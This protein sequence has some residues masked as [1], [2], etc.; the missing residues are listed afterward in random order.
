MKQDDKW[1]YE[2]CDFRQRDFV[3]DEVK[4]IHVQSY[5][6]LFDEN[7]IIKKVTIKGKNYFYSIH[8]DH[9]EDALRIRIKVIAQIASNS[10]ERI[11]K[12]IRESIEC[13]H[14]FNLTA[15]LKS[16]N[17]SRKKKEYIESALIMSKLTEK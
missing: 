9:Y 13:N 7:K 16:N 12:F 11:D 1:C 3:I 8:E 10:K 5:Q 14:A 6:D 2:Y 17:V 4:I 15:L